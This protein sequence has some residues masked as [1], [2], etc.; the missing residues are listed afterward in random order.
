MNR[1]LAM[2]KIK[3]F[4]FDM[5]YT[6]AGKIYS[7]HYKNIFNGL[8]VPLIDFGCLKLKQMIY[9]A[10][11]SLTSLGFLTVSHVGDTETDIFKT[12]KIFD[13]LIDIS[14]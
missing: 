3:C 8:F 7:H 1:S 2:E 6:L 9:Y 11:F 10:F 13:S 4:G 14:K 12:E 5:D